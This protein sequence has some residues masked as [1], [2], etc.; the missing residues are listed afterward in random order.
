[1]ILLRQLKVGTAEPE[2]I[3]VDN[4]G[5]LCELGNRHTYADRASDAV[6]WAPYDI[7]SRCA[8]KPQYHHVMRAVV[9]VAAENDWLA[10]GKT[11]DDRF[12]E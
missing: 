2:T 6:V 4:A 9:E 1:M 7:F 5:V 3:A 11:G 12:D 10:V 8:L